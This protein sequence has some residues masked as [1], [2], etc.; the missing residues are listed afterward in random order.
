MTQKV[1]SGLSYLAS[2]ALL[3]LILVTGAKAAAAPSSIFSEGDS[4]YPLFDPG[5]VLQS[6]SG[7]YYAD[8][9]GNGSFVVSQGTDP[10]TSGIRSVF[11]TSPGPSGARFDAALVDGTFQIVNLTT[12]GILTNLPAFAHTPPNTPTTMALADNGALTITVKDVDGSIRQTFSDSVN[13]PVVAYDLTGVSYD[14]AH[15]TV[16][17]TSQVAG[18][19]DTLRNE[20]SEAQVFPASVSLS[21][22][23]TSSWS[24]GV[25]E[26]I[27]I[28]AKASLKVGVPDVGEATGEL[29]IASTTTISVV[30]GG[31]TSDTKTFTAGAQVTVPAHSV[32]QAVLTGTKETFSVPFTYTGNV[33]YQDGVVAPVEGSG[34]FT[35]EDTGIFQTAII[36]VTQ[37]GGCGSGGNL[38]DLLPAGFLVPGSAV[39][40]AFP[41]DAVPELSTWAMLLI[42]FAGLGFAGYRQTGN[43]RAAM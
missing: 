20:T 34:V 8:F 9:L 23:D 35:G 33:T 38:S 15:P 6:P 22:T 26:A 40:A 17:S 30:T 27:S 1:V 36:C 10:A 42:G 41:A 37:P 24:F 43:G 3:S 16:S 13:D 12:G 25:S 4:D 19:V 39:V 5:L 2:A 29:D 21:H 18:E 31:G 7:V 14:L 11:S 32:Y 28:T